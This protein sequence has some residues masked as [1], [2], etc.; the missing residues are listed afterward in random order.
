MTPS[1]S[2]EKLVKRR[3]QNKSAQQKF[4][5]ENRNAYMLSNRECQKRFREFK[6]VSEALLNLAWNVS[7]IF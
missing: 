1:E 2:Y 4:R 5:K 7:E 6:K 3:E